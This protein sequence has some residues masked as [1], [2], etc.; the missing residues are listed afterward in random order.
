MG[1]WV[2]RT[3]DAVLAGTDGSVT[4]DR[5]TASSP[6]ATGI[7]TRRSTTVV[8]TL[9]NDIQ[10]YVQQQVQQARTY[11]GLTT[12]RPSPW[13]PR[14]AVL[15]MANDNTFDPRRKA[16]GARA[17]SSWATRRCRRPSS[18]AHSR[19]AS[20]VIEARVE[21]PRR[22]LLRCL[23]IRWA[24]YRALDAWKHGIDIYTTRGCSGKSHSTSAR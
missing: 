19:R 6:A 8:L 7:G 10:F 3:L 17:T 13:T 20:A 14:P 18:R 16:S 12:S 23:S 4:Y 1:C 9:D 11:R 5:G 24:C 2:W 22:E 21:Q 15:V